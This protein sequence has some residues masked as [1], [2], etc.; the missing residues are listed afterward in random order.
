MYME[1]YGSGEK[2]VFLHG[3]GGNCS[4]WYFQRPL[5][6]VS[7]V[8]MLDLPGHGKSGGN[9][10]KSIEGYVDSVR[11]LLLKT[12]DSPCYLAGHSM[13]GLIAM[14]LALTSPE[15]IKGLILVGSGA[16]LRVF[17]H[18]L[19][20]VLKDKEETVKSIMEFC[21]SKKTD[22]TLIKACLT[23]TVKTSQEVIYSDF[24]ACDHGDIMERV[25][26]IGA[27]TLI[28]CGNDDF[29]TPPKYSEYLN[30]EIRQSELVLVLDAGHMVMLEKPEETNRAIEAFLSHQ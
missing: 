16:R 6:A 23:E 27:P 14:H 11:E 28:I 12:G 17:P 7:E 9:G 26:E 24:Y 13:G 1:R 21:F 20:G 3:A 10:S 15:L 22:S 4:S 19:E 5:Q 25:K 8:I 29:M 2:I 18:I 30:R